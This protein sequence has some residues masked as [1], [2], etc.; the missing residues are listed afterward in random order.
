[1]TRLAK[2]EIVADV[3]R[4]ADAAASN[5]SRAVVEGYE[6]TLADGVVRAIV[7]GTSAPPGDS[8]FKTLTR[9]LAVA[10]QVRYSFIAERVQGRPSVVSL[11]AL[12][13]GEDFEGTFE[14]ETKGTPC[15][16]VVSADLAFF[17]QG[18]QERFPRDAWLREIGAQ[19]YLAV[20]LFDESQRPLG[21]LGVL[22]NVPLDEHHAYAGILRLFAVRASAEL[23]RYR[24]QRTL[25]QRE[26]RNRAIIEAVPDM[27]FVLDREGT[28]V[29]F[30]SAPGVEPYVPPNEFL[31]KTSRDVLPEDVADPI[32]ECVSRT[33]ETGKMQHIEYHLEL[34]DGTHSYDARFVPADSEKVVL[35]VRDIT[36]ERWLSG[37][38]IRR[39]ARDQLDGQVE[40]RM[41]EKNPYRLTFRESS[42]L[43][44]LKDGSTDKEIAQRLGISVFTVNKHVSNILAKMKAAS[45]TEA[46]IRA[47]E[48]GIIG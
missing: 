22:H 47:L 14:Y 13:N 38:D 6:R 27:I 18:V 40:Q 41:Q 20:P 44:V 31:G 42:V 43:H 48:E 32:L 45:R 9:N 24:A 2:Q 36:A 28:Y 23:A 29:D 5:T 39:A 26:A 34:E 16:H 35:V 8:F 10:L 11:L 46:T 7:A 4:A 12:W 17:S 19:S 37:E 1:M 21:H 25:A 30:E 15:E 3:P 33:L